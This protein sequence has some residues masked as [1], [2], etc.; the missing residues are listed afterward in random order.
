MHL[1]GRED[2]TFPVGIAAYEKRG[3][4]INSPEWQSANCIQCNQ[5]SYVCPHAAIRPFLLTDAEVAA[6]PEGTTVIQ[7]IGNTKAYKFRIQLSVYDC[8]GCGNCADVCPAK[9]KALVMKPFESQLGEATRWTYMHEKVGYK[10]TVVDKMVNVKN[11]QFAQPLFE[12]SGACAGCGETPYIK[13]VTQLFGDRMMVFK[14]NWLL[15]NLWWI[16]SLYTLYN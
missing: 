3:I 10:E 5:C 1:R 14:C 11:S 15:F 2:G 7:G 9:T 13:T 16:G 6:A 12:F 8:T 4:A